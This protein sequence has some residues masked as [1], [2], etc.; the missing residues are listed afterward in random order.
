MYQTS[1]TKVKWFPEAA[2]I[3]KLVLRLSLRFTTAMTLSRFVSCSFKSASSP[4]WQA[5]WREFTGTSGS[6]C[7]TW[8]QFSIS[9]VTD[10]FAEELWSEYKCST[11]LY[12]ITSGT[13]SSAVKQLLRTA[14]VLRVKFSSVVLFFSISWKRKWGW[15]LRLKWGGGYPHSWYSSKRAF[16]H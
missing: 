12:R 15:N 1:Y 3:S 7:K 8:K 11:R 5:R 4:C 10:T 14:T 13:N 9:P 2:Y 6:H 16:H